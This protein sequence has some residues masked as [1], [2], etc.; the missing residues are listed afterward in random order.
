M[1]PFGSQIPLTFRS[2]S[3]VSGHRRK[4]CSRPARKDVE[5]NAPA[6]ASAV[7]ASPNSAATFS[8]LLFVGRVVEEVEL[9]V[10]RPALLD[11]LD[12]D[13]HLFPGISVAL[14]RILHQFA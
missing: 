13:T 2:T 10:A 9:Q 3:T 5:K 8:D 4:R 6:S 11:R 14:Q 7:L 12:I 1:T